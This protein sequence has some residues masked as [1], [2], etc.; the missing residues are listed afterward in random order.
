MNL[1]AKTGTIW[2][3]RGIASV[4]FG[5]L[6]LLRPGASI[7]ALV[8][9]IVNLACSEPDQEVAPGSPAAQATDVR[10]TAVANVA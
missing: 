6:T 9:L 5:V 3:V 2:V 1:L 7:A 8:L 10:R 4:I